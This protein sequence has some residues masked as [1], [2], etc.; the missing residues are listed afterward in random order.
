MNLEGVIMTE[1][2]IENRWPEL[3]EHLDRTQRN[4]VVQSL[5]AAWHEGWE[6]NRQDVV[7]LIDDALGEIDE[8]EYLRR[9]RQAAQRAT[10]TTSA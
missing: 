10:P 3:F 2:E 4:A 7:D 1:F 5:A 6:P 9:A 8:A